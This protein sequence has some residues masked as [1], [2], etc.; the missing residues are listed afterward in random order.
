MTIISDL[1]EHL[2]EEIVSRVPLKLMRTV[3]LTC[4]K[5]ETLY[6]SQSFSKLQ[7]GKTT[8]SKEGESMMVAVMDFSL[9]LMSLVFA[10]DGEP[11][12]Q[13][14]G[15][16]TCDNEQVKISQ[17]FHCDGLLSCILKADRTKVMVWNPYW[18]ETRCIEFRYTHL[19]CEWDWCSYALGYEDKNSCRSYKLLR[20]IDHGNHVP[21][22]QELFLYEIY[23][24]DSGLWKTL[25]VTPNWRIA[26]Y[27][28]GVSLKGDTYWYASERNSD[29]DLDSHIICFDFTNETFGPLLR[30]PFNVGNDDYVTLS[31]VSREEKLAVLLGHIH[32]RP[33]EFEIWISTKIEA[34]KVSWS[35][36][37]TR[38]TRPYFIA[39]T[40]FTDEEKKV[41]ISFKQDYCRKT[42]SIIEEAEY[43]KELYVRELA[44]LRCRPNACSYVPSLV[45]IKQP[46]GGGK[47]ETQ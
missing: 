32:I 35:K 41:V 27:Q 40:I 24:F 26:Y 8:A 20:Y 30:L 5:W 47:K 3:R 43:C 38:D 36:F 14:K 21:K 42:F 22:Q 34:E 37:L 6:K 11:S 44:D 25:N 19:T 10:V 18:G 28:R 13:T 23:D 4:K 1:P 16:L 31:C 7:F 9:Y 15:T 2:V 45:Q 17:V 12:I 46:A 39:D 29:D 33:E